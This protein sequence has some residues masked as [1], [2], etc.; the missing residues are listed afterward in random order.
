MDK[1]IVVVVATGTA[2]ATGVAGET[3]ERTREW[4]VAWQVSAR[5]NGDGI[6]AFVDYTRGRRTHRDERTFHTMWKAVAHARATA[7]MLC[8][9]GPDA[10]VFGS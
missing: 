4:D 5:D 10:L 1:A 9:L 6:E 8:V 7:T 2:R 3:Y